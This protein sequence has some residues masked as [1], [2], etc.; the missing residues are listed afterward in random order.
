M[1]NTIHT[2]RNEY[3]A[4]LRKANEA[5]LEQHIAKTI[6]D[7]TGSYFVDQDLVERLAKETACLMPDGTRLNIL[8]S[9]TPE[10]I[11]QIVEHRHQKKV[12][13]GRGY[14]IAIGIGV[15][16]AALSVII[17]F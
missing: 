10:Q 15:I 2:N 8:Y 12:K 17:N 16:I 13:K 3:Y 14:I 11:L 6:R 1:K 7:H 4:R 9:L 5:R